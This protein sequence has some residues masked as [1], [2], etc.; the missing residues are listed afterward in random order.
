MGKFSEIHFR[1]YIVKTINYRYIELYN[2]KG[3][4]WEWKYILSTKLLKSENIL[5]QNLI[6]IRSILSVAVIKIF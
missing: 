1:L 5:L 3:E 4:K 6:K 2:S